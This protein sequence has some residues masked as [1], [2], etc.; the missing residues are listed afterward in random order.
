MANNTKDIEQLIKRGRAEGWTVTKT[1][2]GHWKWTHPKLERAI[3]TSATPSDWR[4]VR[5]HEALM[6]KVTRE[7]APISDNKTKSVVRGY[8][9]Q[10]SKLHGTNRSP[11]LD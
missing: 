3:F 11:V 10:I 9:K 6:A 1:N 7:S 2:G 5:N 8:R 4:A